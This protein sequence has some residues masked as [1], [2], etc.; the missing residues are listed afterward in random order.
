MA[1]QQGSNAPGSPSGIAN[2]DD[3]EAANQRKPGV[4]AAAE[5]PPATDKPASQPPAGDDQGKPEPDAV[6]K[7]LEAIRSGEAS[8]VDDEGTPKQPQAKKPEEP[9]KTVTDKAAEPKPKAPEAQT[10]EDPLSDWSP[11]E[12]QHTKGKVKERFR[13]L[14]EQFKTEKNQREAAEKRSKELEDDANY[15]RAFRT[16]GEE[17]QVKEDF[18]ALEDE[19][20][21]HAVK[22]QAAVVRAAKAA[23]AG[24]QPNAADLAA[25]SDLRQGLTLVEER[26]GIAKQAP[27]IDTAAF[28]A[29]L[30]EADTTGDTTKLRELVDKLSAGTKA[31]ER[32]QQLPPAR[33]PEPQPVARRETQQQPAVDTWAV[34]TSQSLVRTGIPADQVET[35]YKGTLVP[36]MQAALVRDYPRLT[37]DVAWSRIPPAQRTAL[38]LE[39][40]AAVQGRRRSAPAPAAPPTT[41]RSGPI[42]TQGRAPAP[43]AQASGDHVVDAI[44]AVREGRASASD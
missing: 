4:E 32:Q 2:E 13:D 31:T 5:S 44:Q 14:H 25:L 16:I 12:K 9:A 41:V 3:Q 33:Q 28:N 24:R 8:T 27:A 40:H 26:L 21:A 39:A 30:E 35:Y 22:S 20:I 7:A 6:A 18:D 23:V 43:R 11:Q 10:N 17:H 15:G 37:P 1:A 19:Q 34:S 29:A 42:R 38:V 36:E